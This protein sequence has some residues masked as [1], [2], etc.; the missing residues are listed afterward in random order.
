M[1]LTQTQ[2]RKLVVETLSEID[3]SSTTVLE[4]SGIENVLDEIA[5][6]WHSAYNESDPSQAALGPEAWKDQVVAA[7]DALRS[8]FEQAYSKIE[9][10]LLNGEFYSDMSRGTGPDRYPRGGGY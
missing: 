5:D 9:T 7:I 1:K 6:T 8:E 2:I 10:K 3:E 4:D